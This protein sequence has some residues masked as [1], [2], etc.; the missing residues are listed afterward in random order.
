M[1][2]IFD[3][4]D[5]TVYLMGADSTVGKYSYLSVKASTRLAASNTAISTYSWLESFYDN[6][7]IRSTSGSEISYQYVRPDSITL[8][9]D[10][11]RINADSLHLKINGSHG[12]AGQV[13]T[14]T[15]G[16]NA[17]WQTPAAGSDD[18][19]ID[20]FSLGS[21]L[22]KISLESD[23]EAAKQV[24]LS[25]YLDNTDSQNLTIEGSGPT[26][27]IAINGG[28]DV[29]ISGG[30]I[31]ALSESPANTLVI[32]ATE[33]D[34]SIT[35]EIQYP[36][37][38]NIVGNYLKLSLIN[39]GRRLDSVNL[40]SYLDNTDAQ[41]LD[42]FST[43]GNVISASISNDGEA[44]K[45][46]NIIN[47]ISNTSS[48][49]NLSTT[50]N[51]ITGS[52]V[53][54]INSN[55]LNLSGNTLTE[56]INGVA[57]TSL[58]IGT[59]VMA[60]TADSISVTVNGV[61]SNKIYLPNVADTDNQ[62]ID[63][64]SLNTKNIWLSLQDDG[65]AKK[66]LYL[67]MML[68]TATNHSGDVSGIYSNLQLGAG[69][70]GTTELA[71]SSVTAV[72]VI[73][74]SID[75]V[76]LKA[77]G[78][79]AGSY[80]FSNITVDND[81]RITTASSGA[82]VDGSITNEIQYVDTLN[83]SGN[84]LKLSLLNDNKRL[85]SVSLASYL[86]NTD[87][88]TLS[89]NGATGEITISG[90]NTIDIDGR[91]LTAEVDGSISNEGSLTVNAG[92]GTTSVISSNTSG[93]TDVTITAGTGIGISESGNN[94]TLTSSITQYTDEQAQDAIGAMIDASLNY[95][96]G[97]PLLQRAALTG[98]VTASAGSN[99][100]T[101]A[102]DAVTSAK[103]LNSTIAT[104]DLADSL[105]TSVKLVSN[106]V[107]TT[108]LA[109]GAVTTL[110]LA[111][112]AVTEVK[113]ISNSVGTTALKTS[114]VTSL[115]ILDGTIATA[116]LADSLITGAKVV[117]NSIDGTQ[118]KASGVTAGSYTF[119][120]LTIDNDGRVTSAS[121]GTEVD[122]STTN[123]AFTIDGDDADTEVISNQTLKFEGAGIIT[124]DYVPASDKLIITGTEVD[125]S[126]TNE[127]QYADT[128]LIASN[129]LKLSLLNDNRRLDSVSLS[130]YLD[131]TDSK[132]LAVLMMV[133]HLLLTY[134]EQQ[135]T[136]PLKR[137]Q[138]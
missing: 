138:E 69:V 19:K 95:V 104:V 116:D 23:G 29:T 113:L 68:D 56:T 127:I 63:T 91:Y 114:A 81:G 115:K 98:D 120:S 72:K 52:N 22:L 45:T 90:G 18:Q 89:W 62:T 65:E 59:N 92:S 126:T 13:L 17:T 119:S 33:V 117:S 35:N 83:I 53:N 121:N 105:I 10:Q 46:A 110:K 122:G 78:V 4:L 39:D 67:G 37:T 111:D 109:S 54:I 60:F 130:S 84:Y 61:Q 38:F 70:V 118:L 106:S 85:D 79:T 31:I 44:T 101:I 16:D 103:I 30:G 132:V 36:D 96:D 47:S 99:T 9:S 135:Q 82:E 66:V 21:N 100:T 108:A 27:D 50:V 32:T 43:S 87:A 58:V 131:N 12:T 86:D 28:T 55:V 123:E 74:N 42:V 3:P 5:E 76:Q 14:A 41:T 7:E 40:A 75:G 48:V 102:N 34:G 77:S 64:F 20:T 8:I 51:G 129:Y 137:E 6:V 88:Q 133:L 15:G 1:G 124:T 80:V 2:L 26:Y 25:G 93:S 134:Q 128:F 73:S 125:G 136:L 57:D 24:D 94:I 11:V 107:G 71:D 49:N 112:S 97:T